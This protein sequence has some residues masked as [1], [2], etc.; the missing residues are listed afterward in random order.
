LLQTLEGL[1]E[2]HGQFDEAAT[3]RQR[4]IALERVA[5]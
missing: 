3:I 1:L 4:R 5:G 2:A